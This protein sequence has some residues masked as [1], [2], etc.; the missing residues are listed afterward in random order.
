MSLCNLIITDFVKSREESR[1]G[2]S[3]DVIGLVADSLD[4]VDGA[5]KWDG[6][7]SQVNHYCVWR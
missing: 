6:N 3:G 1:P 2:R 7:M 5:L 4:E